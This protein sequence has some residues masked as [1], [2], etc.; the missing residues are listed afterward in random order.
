MWNIVKK[1]K[2]QNI[3]TEEEEETQTK[4]MNQIY[5]KIREENSQIRNLYRYKKHTG[6]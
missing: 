3:G 1:P 4:D 5:N 2:P 6:H